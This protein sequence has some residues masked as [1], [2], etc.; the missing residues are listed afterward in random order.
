M[1][2]YCISDVHVVLK[3]IRMIIDYICN[4]MRYKKFLADL[5]LLKRKRRISVRFCTSKNSI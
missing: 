3:I 5:S 1:Y 4:I 2:T